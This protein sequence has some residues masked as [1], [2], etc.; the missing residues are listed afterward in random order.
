MKKRLLAL[1]G[2]VCSLVAVSSLVTGVSFAI[3]N[4]SLPSQSTSITAGSVSVGSPEV[5]SACVL[6]GVLPGA[7][8]TSACTFSV[9]YTG[10]VP[11]YVGAD[12]LV[13]SGDATHTALWDGTVNGLQLSLDS[14]SQIDAVP[15]SALANCSVVGSQ[16]GTFPA[17]LTC[18]EVN[19]VVLTTTPMS[20]GTLYT[21]H[22]NWTM[23]TTS[24]N[25]N[26]GGSA[27][28]YVNFHAVQ[29]GNNT[30][31]CSS[32]ATLGQSCVPAGTFGW[33]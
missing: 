16:F 22:L 7:S 3:F 32:P 28:I 19:N 8:S 12:V 20:N 10:T 25:A 23:P 26:Q 24:V 33:G 11:A 5:T 31:D 1:A 27:Q 2:T 29:S 9:T 15:T 13:V 21:L 4:D 17:A 14:G 18:G 6:S 30:L